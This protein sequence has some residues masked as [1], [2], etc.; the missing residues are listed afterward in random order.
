MLLAAFALTELIL[1]QQQTQPILY[2]AL[3]FISLPATLFLSYRY[4]KPVAFIGVSLLY[5]LSAYSGTIAA[6]PFSIEEAS[7]RYLL[8]QQFE[9]V[10]SSTILIA[11]TIVDERQNAYKKLAAGYIS[12]E[13][14]IKERTSELEYSNQLLLQEFAIREEIE[15]QLIE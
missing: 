11:S 14:M 8:I 5:T 13:E 4:P 7:L 15:Q 10:L 9:L 2:T 6:P 3:I 12:I 1:K